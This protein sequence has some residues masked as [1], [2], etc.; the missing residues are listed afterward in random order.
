MD[1]TVKTGRPH[2][3][4]SGCLV[5]GVYEKG[6]PGP[7]MESVDKACKGR[8]SEL[9]A[10]GDLSGKPGHT[11]L[12]TGLEGLR[13]ERLLVVGLGRERDLNARTWRKALA[14]TFA[15]L[16]DCGARSA[17]YCLHQA[18][19]KGHD[20]DW[21]MRDSVQQHMLA[22]YR[23][24][25]CKSKPEREAPRLQQ[26]ALL[27]DDKES[28]EAAEAAVATGSAIAGGMNLARELGNLP[29]NICTPSY[30]AEQARELHERFADVTLDILDEAAMAE[31]GMGSLLSVSRGSEQEARLIVLEYRGAG[32]KSRPHV[33]VGKGI[34]FDTGG[35]SLK[36]GAAMDEMKFDMCGAASALGTFQAVADLGLPINL[37]AVI[38]AAENMPGGRATKPGDIVTSLSGKT[39]EILNTD[40]EGRLVLCDALTY[41]ER[42]K[43]ASVIDIATLTGACI[44]ALGHHVHGLMGNNTGL[45]NALLAAGKRS[46]DRAWELPLGEE[47]DEQ[48]KSNFAD[49][50][51]IGGRSAGTITAG[52]FLARFAQKYRWAHLDIAGTAWTSGDRKGATGRPVALLTQ[53]LLDQAAKGR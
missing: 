16:A 30:L 34:T 38:A 9:V 25:A 32:G 27:I 24:T 13:S 17:V 3:Q 46:E 15:A 49:M 10:S 42:Y 41:V 7:G 5:I 37:V 19:V 44:I 40:A 23:F 2:K 35:I 47:W 4:V 20:R 45:V 8:L 52:C 50:Q 43:P 6:R 31:L 11:R 33:L 28:V 29:G 1:Y 36:P 53:Y 12:L 21:L 22:G 14:A 26:F 18:P 48:L 51:N 39:I